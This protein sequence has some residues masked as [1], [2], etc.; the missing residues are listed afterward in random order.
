MAYGIL[1]KNS[2]GQ[3][4]ISESY[5]VHQV[6]KT[7]TSGVLAPVVGR[8]GVYFTAA[9]TTNISYAEPGEI[10]LWVKPTATPSG[11]T[12]STSW[13][14]WTEDP[15][16][17][18][19]YSHSSNTFDYLLTGPPK[20]FSGTWDS[21]NHGLEIFDSAGS[22][23]FTSNLPIV[24]AQNTAF[25]ASRGGTTGTLGTI[26]SST[27]WSNIGY[28][29]LQPFYRSR[30][31]YDAGTSRWY[32]ASP[33]SMTNNSTGL[34]IMCG[35]GAYFWKSGSTYYLS[36]KHTWYNDTDEGLG[37]SDTNFGTDNRY[38]ITATRG[39]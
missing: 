31:E 20:R 4:Q 21:G 36:A 10:L 33:W 37:T 5:M 1:V 39:N 34:N 7:G 29:L 30:E 16:G 2:S 24:K 27:T 18:F 6:L 12:S 35:P 15:G 25:L 26:T 23:I 32:G 17:A 8:T 13:I 28:A 3:I 9:D 22:T 19:V 38:H 14:Y 11:S